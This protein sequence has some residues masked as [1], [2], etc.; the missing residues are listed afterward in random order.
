MGRDPLGAFSYLGSGP[1]IGRRH[2]LAPGVS[3]M[4]KC[5]NQIIVSGDEIIKLNIE[6]EADAFLRTELAKS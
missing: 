5:E 1:S 4:T 3:F 2:G 6:Q